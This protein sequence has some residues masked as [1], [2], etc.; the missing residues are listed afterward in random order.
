MGASDKT[1]N[2]DLPIFLGSDIPTWLGDWNSAMTAIDTALKANQT[3]ATQAEQKATQAQTDIQ[4]LN[5]KVTQLTT[6]L[7]TITEQQ[8]EQD[9]QI[10]TLQTKVAA[11]EVQIT[12]LQARATILNYTF[13][14]KLLQSYTELDLNGSEA[15]AYFAMP[16]T[17]ALIG[18]WIN[19]TR[20]LALN[21]TSTILAKHLTTNGD[22]VQIGIATGNPFYLPTQYYGEDYIILYKIGKYFSQSAVTGSVYAYYEPS[23][24]STLILVHRS[25]SNGTTL[26]YGTI[27]PA[28]NFQANLNLN[29]TTFN[30]DPVWE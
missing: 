2:Y 8:T 12:D 3:A 22:I 1:T 25:A 24:H 11:Q 18:L 16:N 23:H 7:S 27:I 14:F 20:E 4:P 17:N 28:P 6:D 21:E 10:S 15:N 29:T 13:T 26:N 19:I 30:N 9:Q 5:T